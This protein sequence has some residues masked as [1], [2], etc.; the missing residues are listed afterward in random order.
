M[1]GSTYISRLTVLETCAGEAKTS[2]E[3]CDR[4]K[5][6]VS[7]AQFSAAFDKLCDIDSQRKPNALRLRTSD[8]L[9]SLA[10]YGSLCDE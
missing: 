4:A 9:T 8:E 3:R 6:V 1:T 7:R 5:L 2:N 10:L